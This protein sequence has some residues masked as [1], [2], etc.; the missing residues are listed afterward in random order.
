MADCRT[1]EEFYQV[2]MHHLPPEQPAGRRGGRPRIDHHALLGVLWYVL[3]T[4]CRWRDATPPSCC[5]R[6]P[7]GARR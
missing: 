1:P 5:S 7:S 6:P 2:T 4:G 3:T